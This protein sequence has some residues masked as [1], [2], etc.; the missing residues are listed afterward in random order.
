MPKNHRNEKHIDYGWGMKCTLP[1][2][3][4]V[5][6]AASVITAAHAEDRPSVTPEYAPCFE[7]SKKKPDWTKCEE[8]I[9]TLLDRHR[10]GEK[11]SGFVSCVPEGTPVAEVRATFHAWIS[12]RPHFAKYTPWDTLSGG[13]SVLYRCPK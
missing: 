5:S 11:V 6:L 7:K 13:L 8:L 2:L 12:K 4:G 9:P 1:I 3:I 10:A